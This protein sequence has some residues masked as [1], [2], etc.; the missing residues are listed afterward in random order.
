M[1]VRVVV[2]VAVAANL[3]AEL[4]EARASCEDEEDARVGL[5]EDAARGGELLAA[6]VERLDD[7][8]AVDPELLRAH[9]GALLCNDEQVLERDAPLVV[10]VA[11]VCR[12]LVED[13]NEVPPRRRPA[14]CPPPP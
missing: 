9:L 11:V 12:R 10:S 7:A 2:G 5:L 1:L 6:V 8:L 13:A 14:R 4:Q 3:L